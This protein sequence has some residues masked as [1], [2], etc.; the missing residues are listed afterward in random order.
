MGPNIELH[1]EELV[2]HGFEGYNK[3]MIGE[4]IEREITRLLQER[5][6]PASFSVETNLGRF[7]AGNFT[8]QP[9]AKAATVGNQI[10]RSVYKGLGNENRGSTESRK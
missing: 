1:V 2:L 8:V 9:N 3:Y 7:N 5:G 6:L 4:A 10:A